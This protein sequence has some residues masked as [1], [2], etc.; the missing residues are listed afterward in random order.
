MASCWCWEL[1]LSSQAGLSYRLICRNLGL[2]ENTVMHIVR[3]IRN[4]A[5]KVVADPKQSDFRKI[6]S[7]SLQKYSA[8]E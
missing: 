3:K 1:A 2:S 6:V 8:S 7:R 4:D 5:F